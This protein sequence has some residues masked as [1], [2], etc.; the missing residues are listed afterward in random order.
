MALNKLG[1][2]RADLCRVDCIRPFAHQAHDHRIIAA[3]TNTGSRQ[4]TIQLYFDAA[5]LWQLFALAQALHKQ[6]GRPHRAYGM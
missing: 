4:R 3:V 1:D 2:A 6:R 5:Y